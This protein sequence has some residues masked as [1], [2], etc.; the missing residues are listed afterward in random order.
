[1][2]MNFTASRSI[3]LCTL[4]AGS[5]L[6]AAHAADLSAV[7][8]GAYEVDDTHAYINFSYNHLGLSNPTLSFDD[9]TVDLDLD[10]ADPTKSTLM[11]K[12]DSAS[13][14]SGSEAWK[15]H[16]V[17]DKFF[18]VTAHPEITFQSNSI[19]GAGD[20]AYKVMG[21]LT[22]KGTA[23][24]V[25]LSVTINAAQDHPMSGDPVIGLDASGS[26]LRSAFGMDTA[27]PFVSDEI[28]LNISVEMKKTAE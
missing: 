28:A 14:L 3:L 2:M 18:D 23:V 15:D 8:A 22:I 13:I 7:P 9:F 12:I 11:V 27:L 25:A 21:D 5:L 16:L 24:P 19:E 26:V 4:M 1:M 6:T 17:G 20:G 10:N